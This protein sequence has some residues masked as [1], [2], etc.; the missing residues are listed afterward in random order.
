M[1]DQPHSA[2]RPDPAHGARL[3]EIRRRGG[4]PEHYLFNS[5]QARYD[6]N[7][8]MAEIDRL[9]KELEAHRG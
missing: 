6:V 4:S 7:F 2:A 9:T 8:L 3:Q 1:T 5:S